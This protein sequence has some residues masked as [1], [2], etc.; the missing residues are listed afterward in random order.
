MDA[1]QIAVGVCKRRINLYRSGITLQ[2]AGHVLHFLERV[3]HVGVGVG[4]CRLNPNG[5]LVMHKGFVQFALLL[6]NGSQVAVSGRK[7]G[8]YFEGFQVEPRSLLDEALFSF[9]VGQ[10]VERIGV[11]R[12]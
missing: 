12:T 10:I 4:K 6:Q 7:F 2:G 5:F 1:G 3:P 8:E 11:S 9:D